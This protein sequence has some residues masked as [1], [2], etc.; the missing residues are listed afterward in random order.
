MGGAAEGG[1]CDGLNHLARGGDVRGGE[2]ARTHV[3]GGGERGSVLQG[4]V[5]ANQ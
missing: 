3:T 1:G 5:G 2:D 4:V